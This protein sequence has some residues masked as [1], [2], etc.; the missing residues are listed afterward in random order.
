MIK[1]EMEITPAPALPVEPGQRPYMDYTGY[2]G[3]VGEDGARLR[4]YWHSV[5]KHVWLILTLVLLVTAGTFT[6]MARK[7]DIYEAQAQVQVDLESNPAMGATKSGPIMLSNTVN[8]P[9]YF[10]TQLRILTSSG[11]L[12]RVVKTLDLEHNREFRAGTGKVSTWQ[13]MLRMVGLG[14]PP[15]KPAAPAADP[16]DKQSLTVSLA[17]ATLQ[18]DLVEAERLAPYVEGLKRSLKVEPVRESR[19]ASR[20]TR[21]IDIRLTH[22]NPQFAA[23]VVNT[24]VDTFALANLEKKTETNTSAGD[25]LQK[26]VAELQ[27]QIRGGEER[28]MNYAASHEILSLDSTTNTVVER[29]TGLNKQ[30]LEA[31]N[32]R[33]LAEAAYQARLAPGAAEAMADSTSRQTTDA[34]IKLAHLQQQR[35]ELLVENTEESPPV[36]AIDRQ[37]ALL[38]KQI[39]ETRQ[40][41][42][43]VALTN[44][45]TGYREAAGREQS[46]REAFNKQRGETL[47]QN[48]AAINYRIIQQEVETQKGFLNGLLQRSKENDVMLAALAGTPNNIHVV[49]YALLPKRP[50]GPRRWLGVVLAFVLSLTLSVGFAIFLD[51]L[52]TSVRSTDEVERV[53][54]LPALTVVPAIGGSGT[55]RLLLSAFNDRKSRRDK[56]ETPLVLDDPR[57]PLA[58][59]FRRLRTSV[60]LSTAG[61][62]PKTIL[63]TSSMPDEGKTTTAVNMALTL[64]SA[65]DKVL[66]I[67]ADMHRPSLHNVF[68]MENGNGL[69]AALVSEI[70]EIRLF[71]MIRRHEQDNLYVMLAGAIPPNPAELLG[72][73]QMKSL[74][75]MLESSFTYIIIDSPPISYF[76]D[77]VL[78]TSVV[79]GVLLVVNSGKTSRDIVRRS[80]KV[81]KDVNARVFGVVLNNVELKPHDYSY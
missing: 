54:Q 26:R 79:D 57:S 29:L 45:E 72:S 78:L 46:L 24:I 33:K 5:R 51:Q 20:E 68:K 38:Q 60:L 28:L 76:T 34:E 49:D 73:K 66:I 40:R 2:A 13:N 37:V 44:L 4:E 77:S 43:E 53:L 22:T 61:H 27:S 52:D 69:S 64:A 23:K 41:A 21:L 10:N 65:G 18:A 58:E 36:V 30:L 56:S 14:G 48:E 62:P 80:R 42:V 63:V 19:L 1:P 6:Y 7:P 47:A 12:G 75:D 35:E 32:T 9:A 8:D 31:E 15:P 25:F 59:A 17:P 3:G 16:S 39:V 71:D 11:L 74:M 70:D 55:R 50:V 67:D 81:L